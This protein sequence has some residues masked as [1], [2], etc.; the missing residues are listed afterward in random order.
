MHVQEGGRA[1]SEGKLFQVCYLDCPDHHQPYLTIVRCWAQI[2]SLLRRIFQNRIL[3]T[4]GQKA[5]KTID[6]CISH[7]LFDEL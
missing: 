2:L 3:A 6:V 5:S 4:L 7:S 1:D